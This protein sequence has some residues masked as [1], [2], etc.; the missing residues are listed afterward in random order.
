MATN[1][2]FSITLSLKDAET[3]KRGLE[4]LGTGGQ[5]ALQKLEQATIPAS[6]ALQLLDEASS[7]VQGGMRELATHSGAVG[8]A[9]T[10]LGNGGL[11]AAAGLGAIAVAAAAIIGHLR[12]VGEA[13]AE[14]NDESQRV[15]VTASQL[16][17]LRDTFI[18]NASSAEELQTALEYLQAKIGEAAHGGATA[19]AQFEAAGISMERLSKIGGDTGAVLLE[20]AKNGNLTSDQIADLTGR[21]GKGLMPVM[22]A[23]REQGIL[24]VNEEFDAAVQHMGAA[25]DRAALLS[26]EWNRMGTESAA[27]L[28][29]ALNGIRQMLIDVTKWLD[30]TSAASQAFWSKIF[31]K[32]AW[33]SLGSMRSAIRE[34]TGIVP[35]SPAEQASAMFPQLRMANTSPQLTITPPTAKGGRSSGGTDPAVRD[36]ERDA[37]A[38]ADLQKEIELFGR[39][40]DEAIDKATSRLSD[41]ATPEQIAQTKELAGQLYDLAEAQ[42]A[43]QEA[44]REHQ[45]LQAEGKRIYEETRTPAEEY[46]DTLAKLNQLQVA[47]VINQTTYNRAMDDAKEKASASDREMADAHQEWL[48]QQ[49]HGLDLMQMTDDAAKMFG[50]AMT[51]A[52]EDA[53]VGGAKLQDVLTALTTDLQKFALRMAL[54]GLLRSGTD[55]LSSWWNS[56]TPLQNNGTAGGTSGGWT[57]GGFQ[58]TPIVNAHGNI[59]DTGHLIPFARGGV[60]DRPTLFPMAQGM[61]LMGEAGPEAVVPL[62][63]TASG[64]LGVK[65]AAPV[66][67]VTV[68]NNSASQVDTQQ[69]RGENGELEMIFNVLDKR[70]AQQAGRRGTSLN[71]AINSSGSLIRGT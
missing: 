60:F 62:K 5:R 9:L 31:S 67:K 32:D 15:G 34:A 41:H 21:V 69:N 26:E 46:A 20:I 24:P 23:L 40:R 68:N 51:T 37:K 64:D 1:Q 39:T 50:S 35:P 65:A 43:A 66:V 47:G 59:F 58:T 42:K 36:A 25:R 17:S 71:R 19:Q 11:A 3:V 10:L 54:A 48:D 33:Q 12:A 22:A 44:E 57:T 4:Q 53:V 55:A 45:K 61:G 38:I 16:S 6:R 30:A 49:S 2:S 70:T 14:L 7:A 52:F 56:S 63:R 27:Q 28:Q 13:M 8:Q 29:D 18:S